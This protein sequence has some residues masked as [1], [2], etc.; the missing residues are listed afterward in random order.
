MNSQQF[1]RISKALADSRRYEILSRIAKCQELA[2]SDIRC[3]LPITAATL[4]HHI[5]ELK[6]ADLI[7]IR[8]AGQFAHFKLRRKVWQDYVSRLSKL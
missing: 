8:R 4:S 2:C 6:N 1:H 5:K 3:E 7:E